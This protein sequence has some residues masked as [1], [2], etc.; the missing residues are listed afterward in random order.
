[1]NEL[2]KLP[3]IVLKSTLKNHAV[4][5]MSVAQIV[6]QLKLIPNLTNFKLNSDLISTIC[7]AVE[8]LETT[9]HKHDKKID[10][11]AIVISIMQQLFSLNTAEVDM[12]SIQI[13]F[14]CENKMVKKVA[15]TTLGK[16]SKHIP[17]FFCKKK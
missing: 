10:K 8:N 12:I 17:S 7:T 16:I 13:D 6:E 11:K 15:K 3:E 1:M 14:L 2:V 9:K 4:T 5:E